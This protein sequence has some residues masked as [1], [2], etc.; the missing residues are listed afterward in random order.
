MGECSCSQIDQE[1]KHSTNDKSNKKIQRFARHFFNFVWE[2]TYAVCQENQLK[3]KRKA[4]VRMNALIIASSSRLTQTK[5]VSI[6]RHVLRK[7]GGD[8]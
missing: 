4:R 1:D 7:V 2:S 6:T 5:S 8:R 3:G